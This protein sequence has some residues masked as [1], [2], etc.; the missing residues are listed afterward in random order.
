MGIENYRKREI[1]KSALSQRKKETD[2]TDKGNIDAI[3]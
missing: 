3:I 1:E 2:K